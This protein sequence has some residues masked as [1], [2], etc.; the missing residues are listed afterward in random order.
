MVY[1]LSSLLLGRCFNDPCV[2]VRGGLLPFLLHGSC[3]ACVAAG[4]AID[5]K[6]APLARK[7]SV[8]I[9]NV[10]VSVMVM[11]R[12]GDASALHRRWCQRLELPL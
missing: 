3:C 12:S 8:G 6:V 9:K 11:C 4:K 2:A 5:E 1:S 7:R 10:V